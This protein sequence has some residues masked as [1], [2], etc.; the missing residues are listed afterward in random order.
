MC[1]HRLYVIFPSLIILLSGLIKASILNSLLKSMVMI[2]K[3]NVID[4]KQ[5]PV[6]FPDGLVVKNSCS[7]AGELVTYLVRVK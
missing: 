5:P 4:F 3:R 2:R 1:T 6:D 7:F